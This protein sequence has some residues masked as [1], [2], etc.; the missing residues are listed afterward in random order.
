[1]L[2]KLDN[3]TNHKITGKD[4][5]A[6][7]SSNTNNEVFFPSTYTNFSE[8]ENILRHNY[9]ILPTSKITF[10]QIQ[11]NNTVD[12]VLVNQIEYR[13]YDE[14]K[15]SLNLDLCNK[16]MTIYYSFKN[17]TKE[18]LDLINNFKK[19]GID[20]LNI[21]DPFFNDLCS[22][23]SESG[24]DLTLNNR[25]EEFYKNYTFCEKN[26]KLEEILYEGKMMVC[27]CT[28]KN[29]LDVKYFNFDL[30]NYKKTKDMNYKIVKCTEAFSSLKNNI[31]FWTF[32][33]LMILNIILLILFC[34]LSI[35]EFKEHMKRELR[36]YGYVLQ[37]EENHI[38][39]HN[40]VKKLDK[41]MERLAQLKK[42]FINNKKSHP[43]PKHKSHFVN[44]TNKSKS[45]HSIL[46]DSSRN[47]SNKGK[48]LNEEINLLKKRMEKTKKSK[49]SKFSKGKDVNELRYSKENLIDL[50]NN[51]NRNKT[52]N[53]END[54]N[55]FEVNLMNINVKNLKKQVHIPN[56]SKHI[57]N[58]YEF[59]EALKYDKRSFCA[60][61]YIFL[62]S[63]QIIMHTFL[64]KSPIE[65]FPVRLSL[66]KFIFGCDLAL[67]AFFYSDDKIAERYRSSKSTFAFALTNNFT[68]II[69][70]ILIGYIFLI[71]FANLNNSTNEIR[72]L[73]RT[74][75]NKIKK[76]NKYKV[77]IKRKKEIILEVK[78]I[79]KK[80]KIKIT[81]FYIIEFLIMILFWYYVTV[82]CHVYKDTQISWLVNTFITIIVRILF[83]ILINSLFA[84]FYIIS[85]N[86]KSNCLYNS[87]V[88]LYCFS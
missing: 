32:L 66:L 84:L 24:K 77:T 64:Y 39:C 19:K 11:I 34:C 9:A 56:E 12:D 46:N 45:N 29:N 58:I 16:N 47:K 85:I 59:E 5:I 48:N 15:I 18:K 82:F 54:K 4:Y 51:K 81:I 67:N 71:F 35:K 17:D 49:F 57:L 21:N 53:E 10:I 20:I 28:I 69:L 72:K 61:Y 78:R 22:S 62:I 37:G 76:D 25:I 1:M 7:I 60:I 26:C 86:S 38:F 80:F 6:Q 88:W 73:F 30:Y 43:P 8:C 42:N 36:K 55:K 68:V 65:P 83:D 50:D 27:N 31:G 33:L 14:N 23:Y 2:N 70:A 41:L 79:I 87:I 75:E 63:K 44:I 3:D 74:E 40:Y 52:E 13:A